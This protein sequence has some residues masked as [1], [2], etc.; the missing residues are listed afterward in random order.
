MYK[1]KTILC[2]ILPILLIGCSTALEHVRVPGKLSGWKIGHQEHERF[3]NNNIREFIPANE[4]IESWS[5]MITVQYSSG[6]KDDPELFMTALK[7][8]MKQRCK[9]TMW[10]V[11]KKD[12]NSILYEW[13]INDCKPHSDQHE[14]VRL[15]RGNDGLHRVAYTEKVKIIL[16]KTRREWINKLSSAYL[17]K[18]GKRVNGFNNL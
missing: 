18:D 10:K 5:K 17:E 3:T 9:N 13:R 14:I 6:Y 7:S 16:S 8:R 2:V 1:F 4:N 12:N 11:L 15:F